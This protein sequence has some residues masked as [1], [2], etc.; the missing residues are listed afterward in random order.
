MTFVR[1]TRGPPNFFCNIETEKKSLLIWITK[2]S[3]NNNNNIDINRKRLRN[4]GQTNKKATWPKK[5]VEQNCTPR[6]GDEYNWEWASFLLVQRL[7]TIEALFIVYL[8]EWYSWRIYL[9]SGV[10]ANKTT[11]NSSSRLPM[12]VC[13]QCLRRI[14]CVNSRQYQSEFH[15]IL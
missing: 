15:A 5:L 6:A 11:A 3:M 1:T 14:H 9:A 8:V 12:G 2:N 13:V 10:R 4:E 7:G